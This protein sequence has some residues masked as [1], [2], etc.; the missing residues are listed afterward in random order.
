MSIKQAGYL[1]LGLISSFY[2]LFP[3]NKKKA[4]FY[5]IHNDHK[6]GN[7][8]YM[9]E[10]LKKEREGEAFIFISKAELFQNKLRGMFYFYFILNFHLMTASEIYLNDNFL[11]LAYMPLRKRTRVVQFWHG[12]GAF[13]RFGL[14]TEKRAEVRRLVIKGNRRLTHLFISGKEVLPFYEEAFQVKREKIYPVGLPVLDFYFDERKREEAREDFFSEYPDLRNKKILLYTPTFRNTLEENKAIL[15][16]FSVRELKESLGE[17][18][19]ILMRLHPSILDCGL[20]NDL[21]EAVY[22]VSSFRDI[23]KLYEVSS[24]LVNDYSS[25]VVEFSLLKKP[26]IFFAPD[27]EEYDRG[28][29]RDYRTTVPGEIVRDFTSLLRAIKAE[30]S[31]YLKNELFLKLHYDYYDSENCKR[32][33]EI[34]TRKEE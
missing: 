29:Y 24:V 18:W 12:V 11:P 22:D 1:F 7:L 3:V 5:M 6:C 23:K 16:A 25:T 32:I 8:K 33:I 21:P 19:A 14:S 26:V 17:D 13:K 28:F 4:V 31:D 27:L 10:A 15:A 30:H 9:Y 20:I 34:L 2:R